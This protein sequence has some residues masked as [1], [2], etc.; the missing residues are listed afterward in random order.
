M[1]HLGHSRATACAAP[2]LLARPGP[3]GHRLHACAQQCVQCCSA[4]THSQAL[5]PLQ[6]DLALV[7]TSM[8]QRQWNLFGAAPKGVGPSL[9]VARPALAQKAVAKPPA[10]EFRRSVMQV[11]RRGAGWLC[12]AGCDNPASSLHAP[13]LASAAWATAAAARGGAADV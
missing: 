9:V 7:S 12:L 1:L 10:P 6:E 11:S 3:A 5:L 2:P 13:M 4:C 8:A